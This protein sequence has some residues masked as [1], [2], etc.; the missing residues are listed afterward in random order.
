MYKNFISNLY[1]KGAGLTKAE[2]TRELFQSSVKDTSVITDKRN[3]DSVY[4]GYNR[5]NS[6]GEIAYDI[7]SQPGNINKS[8][9]E[10]LIEKYLNKKPSEKS[11][12]EQK[13]CG[14]FKNVIPDI[15]PENLCGRIAE[16]FIDEV[17]KP[18]AEEYEKATASAKDNSTRKVLTHVQE[19]KS[20]KSAIDNHSKDNSVTTTNTSTT[21]N[22]TLVEDNIRNTITLNTSSKNMDELDELKT[23]IKNL[24]SCFMNLKTTGINIHMSSWLCSEEEQKEKEQEFK[25]TKSD[26]IIEHK[27][28]YYYYRS[29]PEL[30]ENFDRMISLSRTLTFWYGY[31]NNEQNHTRLE[32]D[33]QIEE[34]SKCINEVWDAL[35]K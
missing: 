23:L 22:I 1:I 12:N 8:G 27:K 25:N 7:I 3:S 5:G 32:C 15:S 18:A 13:I 21:N 6:I 16:F 29:F 9:I 30:T 17:L 20:V 11:E 26:F 2:L 10:N 34:Y 19:G 4:K 14:K 33:Y 28:L 24:D 35:S 31:K